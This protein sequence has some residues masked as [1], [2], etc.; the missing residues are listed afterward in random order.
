MEQDSSS[1]ILSIAPGTWGHRKFK[2]KNRF[3]Q[4]SDADLHYVPGQETDLLQ[5]LSQRLSLSMNEMAN[6]I[7]VI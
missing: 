7:A 3:K 4:L 5:R 1:T 6:I 2:L